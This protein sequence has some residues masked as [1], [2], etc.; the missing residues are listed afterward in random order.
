MRSRFLRWWR[1]RRR[2]VLIP[3]GR[4]PGPPM[5]VTFFSPPVVALERTHDHRATPEQIAAEAV[6]SAR[7][8]RRRKGYAYY[9]V[10]EPVCGRDASGHWVGEGDRMILRA[11]CLIPSPVLRLP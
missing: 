11:I 5:P 10:S 9:Q 3:D 2:I 4:Q 8:L 7:L 6:G 1:E